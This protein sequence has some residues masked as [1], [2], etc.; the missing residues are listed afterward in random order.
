MALNSSTSSAPYPF[1]DPEADL[2]IESSDNVRFRVHRSLL[3]L[4]S[5]I[6]KSMLSLPQPLVITDMEHESALKDNVIPLPESNQV[7][8]ILLSCCDPRVQPNFSSLDFDCIVQTI[9]AGTKYDIGCISPMLFHHLHYHVSKA[10]LRTYAIA[11]S[12]LLSG[13]GD[14][15]EAK[16]LARVAAKELLKYR[17][18][19]TESLPDTPEIWRIP[20]KYMESLY[21]YHCAC[22]KAVLVILDRCK[23]LT[24]PGETMK[25]PNNSC[26]CVLKIFEP[27]DY[28]SRE[29]GIWWHFFITSLRD[30]LPATPSPDASYDRKWEINGLLRRVRSGT[31]RSFGY[32]ES[33][34]CQECQGWYKTQITEFYS[35]LS[36]EIRKD[37]QKVSNSVP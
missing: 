28:G 9:H 23:S 6:F 29:V 36:D 10:P 32:S 31:S 16:L 33:V 3:A 18:P 8:T 5:P 4:A 26:R 1:D 2:I 34:A 15:G 27:V 35:C 13:Q 14:V 30:L 24:L 17:I 37:I 11:I 19:L 7:L 25:F 21:S 20:F 22:S 12:V